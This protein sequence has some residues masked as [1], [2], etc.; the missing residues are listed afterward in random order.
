MLLMNTEDNNNDSKQIR[1]FKQ[2]K[3]L[4]NLFGL[5]F[6]FSE[7]NYS[8]EDLINWLNNAKFDREKFKI[9]ESIPDLEED[10]IELLEKLLNFNPKER[11]TAK[12]ALKMP[13]FQSFQNFNKDEFKKKKFKGNN[14]DL[15]LF[16]KN[17]EKEYQK[18][19]KDSPHKKTEIL[20]KN[21]LNFFI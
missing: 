14:G 1:L 12:E 21:F 20:K 11:I 4:S 13:Y 16:L 5:H 9:F 15:T 10:A 17:L 19:E 8:K 3:Y 7:N 18:V 2:L 6:N